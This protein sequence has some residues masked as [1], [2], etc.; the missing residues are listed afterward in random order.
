MKIIKKNNRITFCLKDLDSFAS[1]FLKPTDIV[2][3]IYYFKH[4]DCLVVKDI[5]NIP[6]K[7][8]KVYLKKDIIYLK[9]NFN[10]DCNK[11][12]IYLMNLGYVKSG[13]LFD[14]IKEYIDS[15]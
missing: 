3:I 6:L 5:D 12:D 10:I 2:E 13:P 7:M 11:E 9:K 4:S 1:N 14:E 15:L 8:S